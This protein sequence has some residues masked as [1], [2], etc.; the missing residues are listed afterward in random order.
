MSFFDVSRSVTCSL[1]WRV[2]LQGNVSR[3][4]GVQ[5]RPE[6]LERL[7]REAHG[8]SDEP[9]F[10]EHSHHVLLFGVSRSVTCS[11]GWRVVLQANVSRRQGVQRRPGLLERLER[12]IHGASDEPTFDEHSHHVL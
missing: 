5:R 3:R 9:A 1:G 12:E 7:E 8:A 11:L 4:H 2:V 10:D 6:L